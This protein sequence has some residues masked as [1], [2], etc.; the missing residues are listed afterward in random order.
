M[1]GK[2]FSTSR[3]QVIYVR[4]VLE[5]Y[6]ADALRYYLMIAGPENQDTDFTW[7]EFVRRNND[8]LVATWG[9]LV[10]RTLVNAH[11]NF[12]AVPE[13]QL[14]TEADQALISEIEEA[15]DQVASQLGQA[16]F[17]VALK[18]AM[19]MAAKVNV[20]LGTEQPW[21]IIK[22]DRERAGTVLY[23]AL[24]CVDNLKTMLTPFLPFSSQ[25]LHRML[26]YEDVIAPQP[27]VREF[28][29]GGAT[30]TG[31]AR[32]GALRGDAPPQNVGD[33]HL[34]LTG[35]YESIDR[36]QPSKLAA[37]TVLP[38]PEALFKRLDEVVE[39]E[40]PASS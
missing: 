28:A 5:R 31:S 1:S 26:G 34:V 2:K 35:T 9:N 10:H 16:R 24:R 21:H 32:L 36:W 18:Y 7:S 8:E 30:R 15:L 6:D 40:S 38:A 20:Y 37:G 14:L 11:R 4:D 17:Q 27:H 29:E 33:K 3:G 19:T 25:R 39:G 12:G 22:T 23:V 13:P